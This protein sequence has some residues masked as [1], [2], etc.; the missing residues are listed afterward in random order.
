MLSLSLLSEGAEAN[1][2]FT[3]PILEHYW[4]QELAARQPGCSAALGQVQAMSIGHGCAKRHS[5]VQAFTGCSRAMPGLHRRSL[6]SITC[7]GQPR[8]L[9]RAQGVC[10]PAATGCPVAPE[11]AAE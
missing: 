6:R 9:C 5:H 3:L 10:V 8:P 7:C 11:A 4:V 1:H 2:S